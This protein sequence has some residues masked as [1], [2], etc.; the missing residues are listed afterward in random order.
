MFTNQLNVFQK[1]LVYKNIT[2]RLFHM[3]MSNAVGQKRLQKVNSLEK[4]IILCLSMYLY[5]LFNFS[6]V[7]SLE[8]FLKVCKKSKLGMI[9]V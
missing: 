5:V 4:T 8:S 2:T 7:L 6:R 3:R 1:F 9:N